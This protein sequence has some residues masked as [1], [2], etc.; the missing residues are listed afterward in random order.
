MWMRAAI[1]ALV[2]AAPVGAAPPVFIK[3]DTIESFDAKATFTATAGELKPAQVALEFET[4]R[5][6]V[7]KS[8]SKVGDSYLATFEYFSDRPLWTHARLVVNGERSNSLSGEV[9]GP[10]FHCISQRPIDRVGLVLVGVVLGIALLGLG[11]LVRPLRRQWLT[12]TLG[13]VTLLFWCATQLY[14]E[15]G[16][17]HPHLLHRYVWT[18]ERD[19]TLRH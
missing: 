4:G 5:R 15:Y 10:G 11:V 17:E 1:L 16:F 2:L 8:V 13:A 7:A 6:V 19:A 12:I 3:L 9:P 14:D 18:A